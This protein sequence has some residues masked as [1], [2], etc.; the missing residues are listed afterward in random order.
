LVCGDSLDQR[1]HGPAAKAAGV[2]QNL[3]SGGRDPA[4]RFIVTRIRM[5]VFGFSRR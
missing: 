5:P 3:A 2:G 1:P 4:R